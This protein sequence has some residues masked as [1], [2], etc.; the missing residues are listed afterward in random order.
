MNEKQLQEIEASIRC[1]PNTRIVSNIR[2]LISEVR[3]LR[4]EG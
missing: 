1:L 2:I 4:G 3:R